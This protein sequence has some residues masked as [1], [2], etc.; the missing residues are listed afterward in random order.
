[1]CASCGARSEL[2]LRPSA[3]DDAGESDAWVIGDA[4]VDEVGV[5]E[6]AR[7]SCLRRGEHIRLSTAVTELD[8]VLALEVGGSMAP[9]IAAL[10][11][12][13]PAVFGQVTAR[14][15]RVRVTLVAFSDFPPFTRAPDRGVRGASRNAGS[16]SEFLFGLEHVGLDDG[17]DPPEAAVMALWRIAEGPPLWSDSPLEGV[18]PDS[19]VGGVCFAER[20]ARVV[21]LITDSPFHDGP[22]GVYPYGD[23]IEPWIDM[24]APTFEATM[25]VLRNRAVHVVGVTSS[26]DGEARE[27]MDLAVSG[28]AAVVDGQPVVA[29]IDATGRGIGNAVVSSLFAAIDDVPRRMVLRS[30][31]RDVRLRP[32]RVVPPGSGRADGDNFDEVRLGSELEVVLEAEGDGRRMATVDILDRGVSVISSVEVCVE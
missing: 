11:E 15:S 9:E 5:D 10:Q 17:G 26:P 20:G 30:S 22:G 8:L 28:T 21:V 29:E 3:A 18:C 7:V 25:L 27:H 31:V 2:V 23:A 13:L 24:A 14:F 12:E 32:V 16:P 6:D 1:M 4:R 19:T